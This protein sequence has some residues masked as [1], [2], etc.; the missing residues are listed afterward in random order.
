MASNLNVAVVKSGLLDTDVLSELKRWGLPVSLVESDGVLDTPEAVV[1]CLREALESEDQN[2]IRSTELDLLGE[3][4][5]NN[6]KGRMH[7]T[8][9]IN[10]TRT[11]VVVSY[12]VTKLGNYAIPWKSEGIADLM[13]DPKS[14]L[15]LE[16][17]KR[18]K[19]SQVDELFFG[20]TKA[21]MLC[22]GDVIDGE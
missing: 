11:S 14:Y 22:T 3:Y 18:I 8:D 5:S 17:G 16:S 9:S 19:F 4:L 20:T 15:K 2:A 21:F 10:D 6:V 12:C 7:L 1:S 13:T